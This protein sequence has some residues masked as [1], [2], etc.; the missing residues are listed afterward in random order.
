MEQF[1]QNFLPAGYMDSLLATLSNNLEFLCK[2]QR[3]FYLG[4][5]ILAVILNLAE[6]ENISYLKN[7]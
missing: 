1:R 5:E 7:P 4:N 3:R 6:I 2:M